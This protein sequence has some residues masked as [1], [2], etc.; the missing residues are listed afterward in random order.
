MDENK[1]AENMGEPHK[2]N[3]PNENYRNHNV[4]NN[5]QITMMIQSKISKPLKKKTK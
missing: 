5:L 2:H 4:N 3:Y 1:L